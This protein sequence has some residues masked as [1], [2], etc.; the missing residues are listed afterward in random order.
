MLRIEF[1]WAGF[2]LIEAVVAVSVFAMAMTS[3]VGVYVSVQR[4]NQSSAA[5]SG[6][7]QNGRFIVEDITK[8]IRNGQID[9]ARYVSRY[10]PSGAPQPSVAELF[11]LDQDGVP[12]RIFR[13][14]TQLILERAPGQIYSTNYSGREVAVLGFAAYVYPALS[15]FPGGTE[16]PTVTIFLDLEANVNARDKLRIPFQTTVASRQYPQ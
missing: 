5:L 6:L 4:L 10:G 7:Q 1:E 11:L 14:G 15:P 2:T 13:Q 12:V 9:Y 8:L 3:I 16:Q